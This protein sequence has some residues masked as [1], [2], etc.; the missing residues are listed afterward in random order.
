[1]PKTVIDIEL[2]GAEPLESYAEIAKQFREQLGKAA[3]DFKGMTRE[4]QKL[5]RQMRETLALRMTEREILRQQDRNWRD[6]NR[7]ESK[8]EGRRGKA[9][10]AAVMNWRELHRMSSAVKGD[11]LGMTEGLF[12]FV[13]G[14]GTAGAVVGTI[15]MATVGAMA[16]LMTSASNIRK[17]AMMLGT[18][19][20]ETQ[21]SNALFA[22]WGDPQAMLAGEAGARADLSKRWAFGAVGMPG[23]WNKEPG[24]ALPELMKLAKANMGKMTDSQGN[25]L[26][27]TPMAQAFQ[28]LGIPIE[29]LRALKETDWKEL[30]QA[31]SEYTETQKKLNEVMSPQVMAQWSVLNAHIQLAGA[32]IEASFIK[33]LAPLAPDLDKFASALAELIDA[34]ADSGM[35]KDSIDSLAVAF[36]ALADLLKLLH[37]GTQETKKIEDQAGMDADQKAA[38]NRQMGFGGQVGLGLGAKL[39]EQIPKLW[40][41]KLDAGKTLSPMFKPFAPSASSWWNPFTAKKP[42]A[43]DATQGAEAPSPPSREPGSPKRGKHAAA[44]PEPVTPAL[45]PGLSFGMGTGGNDPGSAA[46]RVTAI[47]ARLQRDLGITQQGAAALLSNLIAEHGGVLSGVG[48]QEKLAQWKIAKGWKGGFGWSQWTASR[49]K[50]YMNWTA[51]QHLDPKSDEANYGY[52]IHELKTNFSK[53]VQELKSHMDPKALAALIEP[54]YEGAGAGVA[55]HAAFANQVFTIIVQDKSTASQ[56]QV[57]AGQMPS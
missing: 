52:L 44:P 57:K 5:A 51:S 55:R 49:R 35:L 26:V 2:K 19:P 9:H 32:T 33:A 47:A 10:K 37:I 14:M 17:T 43:P 11:V 3:G 31:V 48:Q 42:E 54:Q 30:N 40:G 8:A 4:G 25:L 18:T 13:G 50:D 34:F 29:T 45:S 21:A 23:G 15:G 38:L 27:N 28:Q 16:A 12:K 41:G 46:R 24:R 22:R 36:K 53:V 56:T 6:Q 1:M 7:E 20:G 39:S